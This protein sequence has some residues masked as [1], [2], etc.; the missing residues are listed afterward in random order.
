[1]CPVPHPRVA[2]GKCR[3]WVLVEKEESTGE[4]NEDSEE[5]AGGGS[6]AWMF[7]VG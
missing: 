3:L 4:N 7:G 5:K 2:E 1:M 6:G